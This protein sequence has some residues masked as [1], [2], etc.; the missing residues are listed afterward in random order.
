[1]YEVMGLTVQVR[2]K[3]TDNMRAKGHTQGAPKADTL[4]IDYAIIEATGKGMEKELAVL[5]A[6]KVIAMVNTRFG[7]FYNTYLDFIH[8]STNR[9]HS[10]HRQ[11]HANTRRASSASPKLIGIH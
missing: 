9:I 6:L 1:L 10:T 8:W 5:K 4:A 2:N 7:L 3:L 11:C